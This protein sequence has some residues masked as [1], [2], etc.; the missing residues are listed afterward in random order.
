MWALN[1]AA[2]VLAT[3][4]GIVVAME[5]GLKGSRLGRSIA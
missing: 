5:Y 4:A 3:F 2:S 1:G